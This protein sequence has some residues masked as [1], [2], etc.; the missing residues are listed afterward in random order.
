MQLNKVLKLEDLF[1]IQALLEDEGYGNCGLEVVIKVRN[2]EI[3]EKVNEEYYYSNNKEGTPPDVDN[4]N[5]K[6]GNINFKYVVDDEE[7]QEFGKFGN[8]Q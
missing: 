1:K 8:N 4:I 5:V 2:R 7:A 6:I 3:F